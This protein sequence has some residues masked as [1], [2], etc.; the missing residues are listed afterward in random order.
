MAP[1]CICA[2]FQKIKAHA[3]A[4]AEEIGSSFSCKEIPLYEA[5][6]EDLNLINLAIDSEE[7]DECDEDWTSKLNINMRHRVKLREVFPTEKE[8]QHA[9]TLCGLF[10]DTTHSSSALSLEWKSK[11]IRSRR[12]S[13]HS[14]D[15]K[16]S[17]SIPHEKEVL[18]AKPDAPLGRKEDKIIQYSRRNFKSKRPGS[19]GA[20]K[21]P[22]DP[23]KLLPEEPSA[24]CSADCSENSRN[25]TETCT[26]KCEMQHEH[27]G[28]VKTGDLTE[29]SVQSQVADPCIAV[30]P[31][32]EIDVQMGNHTLD[33]AFMKDD[34]ICDSTQDGF[35]LQHEDEVVEDIREKT[36]VCC[37]ELSGDSPAVT[38]QVTENIEIERENQTAVEISM[39]S[40][41]CDVMVTMDDFEGRPSANEDVSVE[42]VSDHANSTGLVADETAVGNFDEPMEK[43]VEE[44]NERKSN[45]EHG[46]GDGI[47][48]NKATSVSVEE[49]LEIERESDTAEEMRS[50]GENCSLLEKRK[51]DRSKRKREV[52]LQT[53]DQS[54]GFDGFIKS[55]CEGLRPR[56]G[57]DATPRSGTDK[58]KAVEDKLAMKKSRNRLVPQKD[59][60]ENRKGSSP[61]ICDVEGC[62]LKFKTK[63]ELG[64]HKRNRCPHEGCGKKF[65]SHKYAVLH[66]RV[67]N[68]D[69][70]LKCPWKGCK[71]SFKW[72]WARTEHLR[73]HTGER[74][75]QCKV[76]GCGLTFRFVSDYS[77]HRR[78]TGHYVNIPK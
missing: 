34:K 39:T 27:Q 35:Q 33:E 41:T 65:R 47:L 54:G 63:A 51:P 52:E 43:A 56:A 68:D 46:S 10:S 31:V 14:D 49:S 29:N 40:E 60:K 15:S 2:D 19:A 12:N 3:T 69:R 11:K 30:N 53:E 28:L 78:K 20:S 13:N 25:T 42:E 73:V 77:R 4:V 58:K 37:S 36:D 26:G 55:P 57:K 61:H 75:Y 71:M 16:P 17:E 9:L 8:Q 74:P 70:P 72:A 21:G 44:A 7:K 18:G 38:A 24:V 62:R 64:L 59:K 67:H 6:K 50:G 1:F 32:I 23:M 76:E 22:G 66:L 48:I 5:S 45:N